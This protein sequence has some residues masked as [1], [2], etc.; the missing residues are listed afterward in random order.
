MESVTRPF[1]YLNLDF[2]SIPDSDPGQK[3]L[4][5]VVDDL[6]LT[7]LLH[8][9]VRIDADTVVEALLSQWLSHYPD[10]VLLHTG[11]R[12]KSLRQPGGSWSCGNVW[13]GSGNG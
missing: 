5:V 7:T 9:C 10:P 8:P 1:E 6:S 2:V 3:H 12:G 11:R 13:M 4:L